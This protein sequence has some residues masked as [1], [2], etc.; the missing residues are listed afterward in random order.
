M[1]GDI[2]L[3]TTVTPP[4]TFYSLEADSYAQATLKKGELSL[5]LW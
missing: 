2:D 3:E 4:T 1:M 5:L